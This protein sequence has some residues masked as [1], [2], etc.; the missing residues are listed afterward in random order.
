MQHKI[1]SKLDS[2]K[3]IRGFSHDELLN[4]CQEIRSYTIDT[5]TEIG[6][7]LAPTLGVVELSVALA[8]CI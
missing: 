7:H 8:L 6:G 4:L 2:P 3:N 5:I 1:L